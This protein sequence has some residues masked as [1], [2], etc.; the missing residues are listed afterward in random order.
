MRFSFY[1]HSCLL[2]SVYF[3]VSLLTFVIVYLN[4]FPAFVFVKILVLILAHFSEV[5]Q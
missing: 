4:L 5:Q 2:S 3:F 1:L